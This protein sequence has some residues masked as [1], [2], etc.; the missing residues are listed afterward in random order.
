VVLVVEDEPG[1]RR[2]CVKGL[3]RLGYRTLGAGDGPEAL[4]VLTSSARIDLLLTD[5]VMPGGM[6]GAELAKA[7][8]RLRPALKVLFMS[9][10][11]PSSFD[12]QTRAQVQ[13]LLSKPFSSA[14]LARFVSQAIRTP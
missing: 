6:S 5:V 8:R 4:G 2:L 9:A 3:E 13:P 12:A 10:Y 7:A 1:V 14:D 11:L